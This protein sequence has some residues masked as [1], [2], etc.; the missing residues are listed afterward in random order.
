MFGR[1]YYSPNA[2]SSGSSS[3]MDCVDLKTGELIYEKNTGADQANT[4]GLGVS[5]TANMFQFGYYYSQDDPNEHGVQNPGWLFSSNYGIGYSPERGFPWLNITNVPSGFESNQPN[6]ENLRFVLSTVSNSNNTYYRLSQ[7]NSSKVIPMIGAGSNPTGLGII[8]NVPL[9][10]TRPT[11]TY[12]NGT[13]WAPMVLTTGPFGAS[14]SIPTST[15]IVQQQTRA[16]TG[17]QH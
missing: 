8:G 12:W 4:G 6:G 15:G 11:N 2:L 17:T 1:L 9:T 3:Y 16:L 13:A 7:W 14:Y 10:P 5:T